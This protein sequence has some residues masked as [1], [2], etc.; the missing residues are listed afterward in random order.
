MPDYLRE[1]YE[2]WVGADGY[3]PTT[4]LEVYLDFLIKEMKDL[5]AEGLHDGS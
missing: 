5:A 3:T 2:V 1:I 4:P